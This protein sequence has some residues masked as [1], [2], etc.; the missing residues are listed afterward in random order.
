M[1]FHFC[2][3]QITKETNGIGVHV[4]FLL[5]TFTVQKWIIWEEYCTS[6]RGLHWINLP[7]QFL[8]MRT[9]DCAFLEKSF[10]LEILCWKGQEQLWMIIGD[11]K[12]TYIRGLHWINLPVSADENTCAFLEKSFP[13]EILFCKVQ[14]QLWMIMEN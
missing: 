12:C 3:S 8:Q 7:W 10:P 2:D 14:E 6:T 9:I 1:P 4:R 5:F 11:L 13:V